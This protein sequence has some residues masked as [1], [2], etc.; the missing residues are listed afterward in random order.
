ME[1]ALD[2]KY[3]LT[4]KEAV[5][6][7]GIK[8]TTLRRILKEQNELVLKNGAKYMIKR[9]AFEEFIGARYCI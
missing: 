1:L 9:K 8:E 6:Y 5:A 4:I 3:L 7:F 2:E